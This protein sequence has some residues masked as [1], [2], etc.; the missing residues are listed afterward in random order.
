MKT[1]WEKVYQTKSPNEVSWTQETPT[2][3]LKLIQSFQLKTS[4]KIIDVG[5]GDSKLVDHL[6]ERGFENI[7]VLDI[8]ENALEK[9][10]KRLGSRAKQINWIACDINNFKPEHSFDL[11]HDRAAFHF[12]TSKEQIKKYC[13][14]ATSSVNKYLVIGAFSK[15]GPVKCS[16]LE[17]RQYD[18]DAL[19]NAFSSG[20]KIIQSLT[21]DHATPFKTSQNFIFSSFEKK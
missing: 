21:E 10:Q 1:H 7:T 12:L 16:G 3:S 5:G 20:F 8:S 15:D 18:S 9:A 2:T 4:A 6:L 14:L 11:W 13:S 17:I 19:S